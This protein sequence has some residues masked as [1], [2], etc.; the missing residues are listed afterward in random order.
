MGKIKVLL[1][2]NKRLRTCTEG[3]VGQELMVWCR[4]FISIPDSRANSENNHLGRDVAVLRGVCCG[5]VQRHRGTDTAPNTNGFGRT[6]CVFSWT[7][8]ILV[9]N[10]RGVTPA[11][12]GP[13]FPL[14]G[15]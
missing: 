11:W 2:P 1:Y 3:L 10:S 15:Y 12:K 4:R 8:S 6:I 14:N 7:K 13:K 9:S 5:A